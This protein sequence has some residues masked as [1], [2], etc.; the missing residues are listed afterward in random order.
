MIHKIH[1]QNFKN[2]QSKFQKFVV[3]I[4]K[5]HSWN[6]KKKQIQNVENAKIQSARNESNLHELAWSAWLPFRWAPNQWILHLTFAVLRSVHHGE[7]CVCEHIVFVYSLAADG[8]CDWVLHRCFIWFSSVGHVLQFRNENEGSESRSSSIA[9]DHRWWRW[10]RHLS[11]LKIVFPYFPFFSEINFIPLDPESDAYNMYRGVEEKCGRYTKNMAYFI[12]VNQT[13]AVVSIFFSIYYVYVGNRD[14]SNYFLPFRFAVPW[15][16]AGYFGWFMLW[17]YNLNAGII[18][19]GVIASVTAYFVCCCFYINGICDHFDL[20]INSLEE[21]LESNQFE[22][23]PVKHQQL[24]QKVNETICKA[25]DSQV[26]ALEWVDFDHFEVDGLEIKIIPDVFLLGFSNWWPRSILE[27][28][29]LCYPRMSFL[30]P[31]PCGT[32]KMW[33]QFFPILSARTIWKSVF[34]FI[35][36]KFF[37]GKFR[38]CAIQFSHRLHRLLTV[39]AVSLL[40]LCKHDNRTSCTR[41]WDGLWF[42]LVPLSSAWA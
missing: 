3:E 24:S 2:S 21:E 9:R 10:R 41:R 18:Y 34:F 30:P 31:S 20:L 36:V 8:C 39:L 40:L 11:I 1:N 15:N 29:S 7:F 25:I 19:A 32:W 14:T 28:F 16:T 13:M 6:F 37:A 12:I 5:I 22:T 42:Q 38:H 35:S 4:S 33:A 17:F 23:D 26:K 27:S